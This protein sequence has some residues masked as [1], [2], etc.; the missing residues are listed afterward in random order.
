VH[1]RRGFDTRYGA[2]RIEKALKVLQSGQADSVGAL[3]QAD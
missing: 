2:K 1:R 3:G